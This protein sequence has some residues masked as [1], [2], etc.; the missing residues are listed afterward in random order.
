MLE[1]LLEEKLALKYEGRILVKDYEGILK[2]YKVEELFNKSA[3]TNI[4]HYE[5]V[6]KFRFIYEDKIKNSKEKYIVIVSEAI[7][8]PYDILKGFYQVD[9]SYENLFPRLNAYKLKTTNNLDLDLLACA[10]QFLF[11]DLSTE[12][13]TEAFINNT[14]FE[15]EYIREYIHYLVGKI[16]ELLTE[17]IPIKDWFL[18][19]NY[20][21]RIN[22]L[23]AK[24]EYK[25]DLQELHGKL[26]EG[27]KDFILK[28]YK[29]LSGDSFFAGPILLNK[30]LDYILLKGKK[31][32]IIVMDGMSV[33]DWLVL[34]DKFDKITFDTKYSM[35][36]IPTIT[37]ISRQSLLSGKLPAQI[38]NPFSLAK[39][40][41]LFIEKCLENGFKEKEIKYHR[42]YDVEIESKDKCMAVVI[43]DIDDLV[44]NQL[45]GK[46]GMYNDILY[47]SKTNKL[48]NLIITLYKSGFEVY[49]ASDHGNTN[50]KG[51]GKVKG[52]G[53]EVETKCKRALIYKDFAS[54]EEAKEEFDLIEYPGY[55]LPKMHKYLL[56]NEGTSFG[57]VNEN[58]MSHGGI[59][60][61]E[62]IVPFIRIKGVENE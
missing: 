4:L 26:S 11:E 38:E 20:K 28:N 45:K 3:F 42:G 49:I 33:A 8:V 48:Q 60:I 18:I 59:S 35:A 52:T 32:A 30:S 17:D 19:A 57:A 6:E 22:N 39:E 41:Q 46:E 62:V 13:A 40:K 21:A 55:Y 7:Y 54:V 53:V 44:H 12:K 51:I 31:F 24:G 56:C 47:L 34:S 10:S 9:I 37:S 29:T 43:N 50:T 15:A 25:T 2:K 36:L 61:E 1:K 23:S 27:F 5:D 58:I 16:R 14:I